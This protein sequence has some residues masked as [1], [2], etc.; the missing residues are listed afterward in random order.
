MRLIARLALVMGL[1]ATSGLAQEFA[2][3]TVTSN[4]QQLLPL[5][6]DPLRP[7]EKQDN[8]LIPH[9]PVLPEELPP[10][11][12]EIILRPPEEPK[13]SESARYKLHLAQ[14]AMR[15]ILPPLAIPPGGTSLAGSP[16]VLVKKFAFEGNHVFSR[17]QL[18]KVVAAY[19]GRDITSEELEE[20]R[21][22]LTKHYVDAGYITSGA[23][24]PDQDVAS[25]VI[26]FQ[27]VEGRLKE[28]D[29]RGNH[30]FRS[31][32]LRNQLRR[33]AGQP[34][35]FN[36]LKVGLQL[37]RQNPTISRVNGEL[38]PGVEPG[39]S[40]LDVSVKDE[41]PFRFGFT[42]SNT[43]PPSVDEGLGE[44]YLTDVNLTGHNDPLDLHW[45]LAR[46]TKEGA[47]NYAGFDNVS[48]TYEFPITPW[49]TTLSVHASKLDSSVVDETF[50]A[51]GITSETKQYGV[52]LHQ[53]VYKTLRDTVTVSLAADWEQSETFLLGEPFTLEPGAI[54]GKA[55]IFATRLTLD[56]TN[57]S[58]VHVLALRSVFN[59]GL[60][61]FGSTRAE[62]VATS[63]ASSEGLDPEVPDSQFFSWVGQ[64]QYV[65]R[66][67][68]TPAWRDKPDEYGWNILRETTLVLR[69]NAQL[70]NRPLLSLE[71]FS[72]GGM[73]SV[74]GYRE[75]QL[76]R[77]DGVFASAEAR[78]PIWLAKDKTPIVSLAPFFDFGDGWNSDK[79]NKSYQTIYSAGVGLLVNATRH[80]Q[81]TVYWG[82]PFVDFHEEKVSLQ[83][84]GLHFSVSINAL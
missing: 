79:L 74:R 80:A 78:V 13:P 73:Q 36:D 77:D 63:G 7:G 32:W 33:A 84:Y 37:L 45:G 20:A 68:D 70:S 5:P 24:L 15:P 72:I 49:D 29:L 48:G 44:L 58:Q 59:L 76:L 83:D 40:I 67:F 51:L 11:P 35:N 55:N 16:H 38:K 56:W 52:A 57:R 42:V 19:E 64:A 22:A 1:A 62:P 43:R 17:R 41:Q 65:R 75:N 66:I 28:I 39:E 26:Q 71:Q 9:L 82:H 53:P 47:I 8:P 54:D 31:W 23:L 10:L 21:V 6:A 14:D 69:V 3:T 60:H 46:W 34:V 4:P 18:A 30:W 81:V 50:A 25:G 61:A 27:I 2:A 12:G